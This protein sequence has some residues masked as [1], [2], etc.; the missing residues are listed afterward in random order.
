MTI[1]ILI[2]SG[3]YTDTIN[4][5]DYTAD[6][7]AV[8]KASTNRDEIDKEMLSGDGPTLPHA[9]KWGVTAISVYEAE[10]ELKGLVCD[11]KWKLSIERL[12]G[13]PCAVLREP[14]KMDNVLQITEDQLPW[15]NALRNLLRAEGHAE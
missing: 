7:I 8:L 5:Q 11:Q 3:K 6:K 4:G 1:Y 12:A 15:F 9:D 2:A 13:E 10:L 14:G